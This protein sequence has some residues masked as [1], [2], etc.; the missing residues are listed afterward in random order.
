VQKEAEALCNKGIDSCKRVCEQKLVVTVGQVTMTFKDRRDQLVRDL[1]AFA[2]NHKGELFTEPKSRALNY[3][4]IGFRLS[5]PTVEELPAAEG[6]RKTAWGQVRDTIRASLTRWLGR[7]RLGAGKPDAAM[8]S[9]SISP[10][11]TVLLAKWKAKEIT[12]AQLA[13]LGHRF[14]AER[15]EFFHEIEAKEM[16][17]YATPASSA[18]AEPGAGAA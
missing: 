16:Q 14:V 2:L 8:F 18:P 4:T 7:L 12:A 9:L 11:K 1:E 13:R 3:G 6:E 17:S 10:N 5:K 15:D